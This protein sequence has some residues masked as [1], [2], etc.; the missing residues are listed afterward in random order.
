MSVVA[1]TIGHFR[2]TW[3]LFWD[4]RVRGGRRLVFV[5]PGLY[6]LLPFRYDL[7]A[8]LL[9]L[10]G[11]LDDWLLFVACTYVFVVICPRKVVSA[12]RAAILLSHPD[13]GTRERALDDRAVLGTL[14]DAE[15]FEMY[16]HPGESVALGVL[17]AVVFGISALGGLWT[18]GLLFLLVALSYIGFVLWARRFRNAAPVSPDL[19]PRIL[20]CL[21][22]CLARLP[23]VPVRVVVS[24]TD[25]LAVGT[26]GLEPPYTLVVGATLADRLDDEE[27]TAMLGHQ[28]GH[29]LFEHTFLS[30]LL[31]GMLYDAGVFAYLWGAVLY[32][33]RRF[34]EETA[35][36][37][38]LLACGELEPVVRLAVK[39][40]MGNVEQPVDVQAVLREV[41]AGSLVP[42]SLSDRLR[43]LVD[44]DAELVALD[45]QRWLSVD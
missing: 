27:L 18:S 37:V 14:S 6:L 44:F 13:R 7:L 9:P 25:E 43:A 38:A 42:R 3:R 35:D 19:H 29:I 11:L 15:Q 28:V 12:Q 8:D 5:V 2:V 36:R 26:L 40:S 31:G 30:S 10:V 21:D 22:R 45:V 41:Y 16:R 24:D 34:S 1:D 17:L 20:A 23:A 39:L 33:W 32:P 4:Q